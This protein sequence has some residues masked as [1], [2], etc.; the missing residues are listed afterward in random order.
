[1]F[2][3]VTLGVGPSHR[4]SNSRALNHLRGRSASTR[5]NESL[6]ITVLSIVSHVTYSL[7]PP[8]FRIIPTRDAAD[9]T[10]SRRDINFRGQTTRLVL[11]RSPTAV[12]TSGTSF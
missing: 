4:S 3:R 12:L 2:R 6:F 10:A 7:V 8:N 11:R 9:G 5:G 1:M